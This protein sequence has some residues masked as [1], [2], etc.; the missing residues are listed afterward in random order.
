MTFC[1]INLKLLRSRIKNN[2]A[3]LRIVTF[4]RKEK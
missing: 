1:I 4:F 3:G 2:S